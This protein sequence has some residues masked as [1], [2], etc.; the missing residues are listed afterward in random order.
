MRQKMLALIVV[1]LGASGAAGQ[2][3]TQCS[4]YNTI[5]TDYFDPA[6]GTV[7]HGSGAHIAAGS[8]QFT[9]TYTSVGLPSC[10]TQCTGVP[11]ITETETGII[12]NLA[13]SHNDGT[14]SAGG[15][16]TAPNGGVSE[17]CGATVAA[18][19]TACLLSCAAS[20]GISVGASGV[21]AS[22]SFPPSQIYAVAP[23][24]T[25]VTCANEPDP[26]YGG[27]EGRGGGTCGDI[28]PN[29]LCDPGGCGYGSPIIVD[30]TGHGFHLT[31]LPDG[32]MFDIA[33]D[34]HPVKIAWTAANSGNAFLALDLNHNG[35]IDS[36]REL[37]GNFTPQ[38]KSA[39]P[40]GYLA[41]AEYDKPVNGGNGD[42]I[43]DSRD[44]IFSKLLLWVDENHDGISQ[45][46]ELHALTELGVYSI[47]LHY[48]DDRSLFDQYGNW[49]HYQGALNPD[50]LDG[51][52]KDG[53]LTYDVFFQVDWSDTTGSHKVT[54]NHPSPSLEKRIEAIDRRLD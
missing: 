51:E 28:A 36:G 24:P 15:Q 10:A 37:F 45:P 47:S 39:S 40:N 16:A 18:T 29:D 2:T 35:K 53:R 43:I 30:T 32:V 17:T 11:A 48:R 7:N 54:T 38:V 25:Q 9:C 21:G 22:I 41:L 8:M 34:G 19:V 1:C 4:D 23:L 50:P 5:T 3:Y 46:N 52:S 27:G 26:T 31:S 33:G 14:N 13:Y 12:V 42:G 44:A 20:I 49:F 6:P